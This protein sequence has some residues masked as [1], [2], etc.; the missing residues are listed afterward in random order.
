MDVQPQATPELKR[1]AG[2]VADT[3]VAMLSTAEA[4]GTLRSRPL[5]T[6]QMDGT[7]ALWFVT[8]ISSPKIAEIDEHRR[9]NLS[10]SD[11]ARQ[12]FASVSGIT[13]ILR[14]EAKARGLWSAT[15]L[16]WLPNGVDD[17]E[18]VLLKVTVEA[19]EVWGPS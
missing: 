13:Q 6:L 9:V 11:P 10:Y 5:T 8:S 1:L 14:D 12:R 18:V 15:L 4:D 3:P 16:P 17:P 2:L 7:G 19:A